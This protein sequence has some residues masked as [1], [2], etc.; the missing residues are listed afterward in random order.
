MQWFWIETLNICYFDITFKILSHSISSGLHKFCALSLQ[1]YFSATVGTPFFEFP[2]ESSHVGVYVFCFSPCLGNMDR[3][4][5]VTVADKVQT[6]LT[7]SEERLTTN[8]AQ[9]MKDHSHKQ[10]KRNFSCQKKTLQHER[11]HQE[12]IVLTNSKVRT[13]NLQTKKL[14][15]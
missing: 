12:M 4:C 7:G 1:K 9:E 13:I 2:D 5:K 10:Q 6:T 15:F 14:N 3:L 8:A 11:G